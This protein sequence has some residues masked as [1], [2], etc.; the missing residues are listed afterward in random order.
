M[1]QRTRIRVRWR[2][3]A[4][5]IGDVLTY[6]TVPLAFPLLVALYY[7]ESA[8]P[9]LVAVGVALAA[10]AGFRSLRDHEA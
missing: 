2:A 1:T 8:V 7:R 4:G 9:F 5:L 10:G 3:S 6:L